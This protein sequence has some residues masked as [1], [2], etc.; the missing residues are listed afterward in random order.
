MSAAVTRTVP[1]H[2]AYDVAVVGAGLGG[3]AAAAC[4]AKAGKHVLIVD[5]GD[6]SG[7]CAH[8]FRRDGYVFDPAIHVTTG[9]EEG[10]IVRD[11]LEALGARDRVEFIALDTF[12]GAFYPAATFVTPPTLEPMIEA[13]CRVVPQAADD[14]ES[15]LRLC[16]QVY[17]ESRQMAFRVGLA[18]M[19]QLV[20][21]FPTF[22]R[23]RTATAGDVLAETVADP[24]AR[25]V[26][27]TL[28]PYAALPPDLLPL[29]QLSA[30]LI[31]LGT[32]PVYCRG[33]FQELAEALVWSITENGGEVLLNTTVDRITLLDGRVSG[34]VLD[35]G[36][37]IRAQ[38]V[39]SN[40]DGR[41]TFETLIGRENVPASV[42]RRLD[43]L[44][45][46]LSAFIV[47]TATTLDLANSGLG[48][49]MFA[50]EQW[51]HEASYRAV[52]DGRPAGMWIS[53]PSLADSSLAP[54]GEN[55][56]IITSLM[57][58]DI[59]EPWPQA[60]ERYT[61]ELLGR[62]DSVLPGFRDKLT[63]VESATPETIESFTR[64]PRGSIYGWALT[65][66]Q[67]GTKR[68]RQET[69][70]GGLYLAGQWT[71]P[72]PS[73]IRVLISGAEAARKIVGY[74]HV[75]ALFDAL[76]RGG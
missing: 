2:D 16:N 5:R 3:L 9:A 75:G 50:Y 31:G 33:G 58:Y 21:E 65:L 34:V 24:R 12:Y 66:D 32:A 38:A 46:S 39:V 15:F 29:T 6:G 23:Y 64:A 4:L 28:W 71:E 26:C 44:E 72:G 40:V 76:R 30:Y 54:T 47:F 57:P 36:A 56:V 73:A 10:G 17:V 43:R 61:D 18:E 11:L 20:R 70:I 60:K 45:L 1:Q 42:L 68:L 7:G 25:A 74:A 51:D 48:H 59:G 52:L 35:N 22:F 53:L 19:N 55:I 14:I 63:Y 13:H 37:E 67:M 62:A 27:T 49:E 69:P 41:Q 8:C